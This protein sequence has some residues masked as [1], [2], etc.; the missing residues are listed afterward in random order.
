L[1][2][3]TGINLL[4]RTGSY[5]LFSILGTPALPGMGVKESRSQTIRLTPDHPLTG[6]REEYAVLP[7]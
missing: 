4:L 3:I 6:E 5:H 1:L 2:V 7:L